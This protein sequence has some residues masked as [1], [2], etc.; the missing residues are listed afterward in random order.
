[1]IT[2][3]LGV[4][5][6][7]FAELKGESAE[8][9]G[10]WAAEEIVRMRELRHE[11]EVV[12]EPNEPE[13][14]AEQLD[15]LMKY[16]PTSSGIGI[17]EYPNSMEVAEPNEEILLITVPAEKEL[18][19]NYVPLHYVLD[20]VGGITDEV[21]FTYKNDKIVCNKLPR[22]AVELI[23]K[24][25]IYC[26]IGNEIYDLPIVFPEP[27]EAESTSTGIISYREPVDECKHENRVSCAVY[28]CGCSTCL[29]CG[30]HLPNEPEYIN[31]SKIYTED[32]LDEIYKD[33][34][35]LGRM[36]KY[37][38]GYGTPPTA[39]YNIAHFIPTWPKYIELDKD[40]LAVIPTERKVS[41]YTE[42]EVK[43]IYPKGTKIYFK[44]KEK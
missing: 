3:V 34:P 33:E 38:Y 30:I 27:N 25:M 40:L 39:Y 20:S 21:V 16:K 23:Y 18:E 7:W 2:L 32:E 14:I 9:R 4:A 41:G 8:Y 10:R 37:L 31:F 29:D 1:M 6:W 43:T 26:N 42:S 13:S 17:V 11:Q 36:A 19:P 22:E 5:A 15:E 28:G 12:T 35:A 24:L 44:D